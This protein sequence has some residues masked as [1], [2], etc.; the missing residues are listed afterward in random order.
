MPKQSS[1]IKIEGSIDDLTFYKTKNGYRVRKK[2]GISGDRIAKDPAFAR[3]RENNREFGDMA[4]AGKLFRRAVIDLMAGVQDDTIVPRLMRKFAAIK[5]LDATSVRGERTV[6]LGL[7][8]DE[9]KSL[10]RGFDFNKGAPLQSVLRKEVELDPETG[11]VTLTDLDP[12]THLSRPEGATHVTFRSGFLN[13]GLDTEEAD[14]SLSAGVNVS[15]NE[16]A[17]T[18]TLVPDSVPEGDGVRV[19][20][21][22]VEFY[23]ALNGGIY[24]LN[25]G[26]H[27]ALSILEV[28]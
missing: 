4:R 10:L 22:L 14:L 9:G 15:L 2:S 23:Q 8:T 3:T 19:H 28:A 6:A 17:A 5:N 13:I 25:N 26:A 16:E 12:G 7:D 21:L 24:P 27:N 11:T 18:I 20:L 1:I